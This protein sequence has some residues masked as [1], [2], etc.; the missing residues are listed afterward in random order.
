[1]Q[2]INHL[3]L[4]HAL[5]KQVVKPSD[6]VIDATCGNGKDTLI[7]ASLTPQG[8]VIALDIQESA[9]TKAKDN[10]PTETTSQVLFYQQSH[11]AF[12][13]QAMAQPISLIVYNLGYLP[14]GDKT[15]TTSVSSTVQSL[16]AAMELIAKGGLISIT[17]YP[18]HPEG[19][20]EQSVLLEKAQQLCPE[21]W[22]VYHYYNLIRKTS[23][24]LITILKM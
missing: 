22:N 7:L 4:A 16:N 21:I 23:P 2:K 11:A 9:I 5:W 17:C 24:S 12:P 1:M 10:L 6:W 18:G 3:H 19:K 14:G 20:K 13:P 8:G 15:L